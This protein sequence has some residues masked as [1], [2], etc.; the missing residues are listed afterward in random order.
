MFDAH[1]ELMIS[2]TQEGLFRR[3]APPGEPLARG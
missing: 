2:I 3:P 1:G